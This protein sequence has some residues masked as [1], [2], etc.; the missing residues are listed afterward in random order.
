[1][2]DV[3]HADLIS[4][5]R[6][7]LQN[8]HA[9]YTGLHDGQVASY[10]PELS[11]AN[12]NWFGICIATT[13]GHVY[14]VGDAKQTFTIQSISKPF[15]YGLALEDRGKDAVLGKIGVE[16]SGDAFNYISLYPASG[17]PFNPMIN[18]GAIA[19][20]GMIDGANPAA[21]LQRVLDMVGGYCGHA[22]AVDQRVYES[23]RSTGHR[24]RAISHML[25]SYDILTGDPEPALDLYFQQCS[26]LV[27]CRDL[28]IM[29]A[30]LANGGI[31][32]M[33][34]QRAVQQRYVE[35]ILSIM[36][37]CGMYNS[38]GEWI[39]DV[40]MPAKSGVS[41]GILAVLPGQLGIA[42]F[43]PPLDERSNSVRGIRVCEDMSQDFNLHLFHA[44]VVAKS[45]IR[46]S[47]TASQVT[48]QRSRS[49]QE[50]QLLQEQGH[51]IRVYDL[52]GDLIFSTIEVVLRDI[53]QHH[54][55]PD[56]IILDLKHVTAIDDTAS[57]LL[58][59]LLS[60]LNMQQCMLL[61]SNIDRAS[62]LTTF[63]LNCEGAAAPQRDFF[64][65]DHDAALEWC[66]NQLL[67][68]YL[69]HP[70]VEVAIP[71][72][73]HLL[74]QGL[75]EDDLNFLQTLLEPL[76]F[77][78]GERIIETGQVADCIYVLTRGEVS[79][80]IEDPGGKQKRLS[81][82]A[83]GMTFG[84]M[85]LIERV[86]RSAD[87]TALTPVDCYALP[88]AVFDRLQAS[89]PGLQTVLLTNM[90]R[91]VSGLLRRLTEKMRVLTD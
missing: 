15:V 65:E 35:P 59:E 40:G 30:T 80:I 71:L 51:R 27:T 69:E 31:N 68:S 20:T 76:S 56:F 7:Y 83:A 24:N 42:V 11:H 50:E 44:P 79:V 89:N 47:Y 73:E 74:C 4:P 38:A 41:G 52:Q 8:L 23:E 12:P 82:L 5:V 57:H 9:T 72:A 21:Q 48:S 85:A 32:P 77:A 62:S 86:P 3:D 36:S 58:L 64:Y 91:H 17:R 10:I 13:D 55:T 88:V 75:S 16:P 29:A 34:G 84:E 33:T 2:S 43:S 49:P 81:T 63:L 6:A 70:S 54:E 60:S 90:L 1:M 25:R 61:F 22:V 46:T 28:A 14:E 19:T 67:A 45:V 39:Y 37:T 53:I 87:I 18:A 78:P 66:E 26:I